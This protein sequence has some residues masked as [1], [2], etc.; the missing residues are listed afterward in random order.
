MAA[1]QKGFRPHLNKARPTT[2]VECAVQTAAV[3]YGLSCFPG[4]RLPQDVEAIARV[5]GALARECLG[6][7]VLLRAEADLGP[8]QR[9]E[10]GELSL[11]AP[12]TDTELT[13]DTPTNY[14]LTI[15]G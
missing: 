5:Y 13:A 15:G 10:G 12:I 7:L 11:D 2:R 9:E 8:Q 3:A 14:G 6:A 4:A 1:L